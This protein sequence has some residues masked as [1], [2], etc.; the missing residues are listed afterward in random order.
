M[1]KTLFPTYR[2]M[3]GQRMTHFLELETA[4]FPTG[5]DPRDLGSGDDQG[6][7]RPTNDVSTD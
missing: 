5:G 6:L 1:R 3:A 7:P 2:Y 4:A